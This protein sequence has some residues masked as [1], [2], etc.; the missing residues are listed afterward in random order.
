MN[1]RGLKLENVP[2][3]LSRLVPV[4]QQWGIADDGY[5]W[6]AVQSATLEQLQ[7]LASCLESEEEQAALTE[8]LTGSIGGSS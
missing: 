2:K 7:F 8:W 3:E 6:D 4:A 5:R 1:R